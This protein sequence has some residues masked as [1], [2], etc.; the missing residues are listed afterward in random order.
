MRPAVWQDSTWIFYANNITISL[1][2]MFT[3]SS[4]RL[5][6]ATY[7]GMQKKSTKTSGFYKKKYSLIYWILFGCL[8]FRHIFGHSFKRSFGRSFGRSLGHSFGR[9]FGRSFGHSFGHSLECS[10]DTFFDTF[11][12]LFWTLFWKLV[13]H[14]TVLNKTLPRATGVGRTRPLSLSCLASIQ[15]MRTNFRI[16]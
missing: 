9:S 12:K 15:S 5:Q 1:M 11:L 7:S 8:F 16:S 13:M 3:L 6:Q 2:V 4:G 10:F 14:T